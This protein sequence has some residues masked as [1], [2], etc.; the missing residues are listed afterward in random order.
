MRTRGSR[1]ENKT[2]LTEEEIQTVKTMW[3][4]LLENSADSGLFIFQNFFELYPEQVHRFSFIRD[5]QGNPIPNY[6]KSQAML[7]H[8]AM[9]MD[10]LDGVITGVFEHDPLLGQMM[11]N[12]GYS[13]HSK[14]I[15][16]DDIEKLSNS[17]LEVIKL[18]AS[19][20]GSGKAKKV[21]AW[22]KLLNIVNERFEQGFGQAE[23]DFAHP[24]TALAN[25]IDRSIDVSIGPESQETSKS[26]TRKM[27]EN[28]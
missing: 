19:C 28:W 20:E 4:G 8:S 26:E 5:S 24:E 7:Q 15:A 1:N 14:N 11:Y 18:V 22:R 3:A 27:V 23:N 25:Q 16:K 9:V 12:A 10:A 6:M 2:T 21:E 17:I 13:H